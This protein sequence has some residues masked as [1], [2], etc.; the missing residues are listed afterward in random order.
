MSPF[1]SV[2]FL[3]AAI[4]ADAVRDTGTA[5]NAV[6]STGHRQRSRVIRGCPPF[7][8]SYAD[9]VAIDRGQEERL[10]VKDIA[11]TSSSCY[12]NSMTADEHDQQWAGNTGSGE[13]AEKEMRVLL[14]AYES[15]TGQDAT[16]ESAGG[17]L[18]RWES[19]HGG[20]C[21]PEVIGKLAAAGD[22]PRTEG[23]RCRADSLPRKRHG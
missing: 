19:M 16:D 20:F 22:F 23:S 3:R 1:D 9:G 21:G 15:P 6:N 12:A 8:F 11:I 10:S 4:Q 17:V 13:V 5:T 7:S 2:S 14:R 18:H